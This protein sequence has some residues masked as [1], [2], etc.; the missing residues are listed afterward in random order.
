MSKRPE[1]NV[2]RWLDPA[3][4]AVMAPDCAAHDDAY[5]RRTGRLKADWA[6][7]KAAWRASRPRA[8]FYGF[9]L[10]SG[11]WWLY[12]DLDKIPKRLARTVLSAVLR[13]GA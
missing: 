10:L 12:Y 6:W 4:A 1:C 2:I 11:G 9:W 13:K 3:F 7:I 5:S 8:V